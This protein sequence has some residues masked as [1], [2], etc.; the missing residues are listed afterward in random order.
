MRIGAISVC[1]FF[2]FLIEGTIAQVFAPEVWGLPW[3]VVPRFV[4]VGVVFIGLYAGRRKALYFGLFFGLLYDVVYTEVIGVYA[5]A[6]AV[7]GYL[8]G[9]SSRYFHQSWFLVL[10][11]VLLVVLVNEWLVYQVY[12]LFNR[13][14]MEALTLLLK[15]MVP[16]TVFNTLFAMLIFRP[17]SK[18]MNK[19]RINQEIA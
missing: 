4:L 3:I 1:M 17:M 13:A 19:S 18:L 10:V 11:N 2:L 8:A 14:S 7:L 16:T 9:L 6:T 5:F 12:H 15:E